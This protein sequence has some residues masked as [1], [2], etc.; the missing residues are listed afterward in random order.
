ME[1]PMKSKIFFLLII[2][3]ILSFSITTNAINDWTIMVYLCG[4]NDLEPFSFYDVDEMEKIGAT[5]GKNGTIE[6]LVLWDRS[7]GYTTTTNDWEGTRL[8]RIVHDTTENSIVSP[9]VDMG[10]KN[11]GDPDTVFDFVDFCSEYYK[12]DKYMLVFWDH[13]DGWY[14]NKRQEELKQSRS[15]CIDETS[16]DSLSTPELNE[17]LGRC[18]SSMGKPFEIVGFDACLMQMFEVEYSLRSYA[19]YMIGSEQTEPG[20]GWPYDKVLDILVKNPDSIDTILEGFVNEYISSYEGNAGWNVTLSAVDLWKLDD[21]AKST[22]DFVNYFYGHFEENYKLFRDA[23]FSVCYYDRNMNVD[24]YHFMS[25][26]AQATTDPSLKNLALDVMEKITAAVK[27]S[28]ITTTNTVGGESLDVTNSFGMAIY[29]PW[30]SEVYD[31]DNYKNLI[32]S[33]YVRWHLVF[34]KFFAYSNG[35]ATGTLSKKIF[36]SEVKILRAR[37]KND[38]TYEYKEVKESDFLSGYSYLV[39]HYPNSPYEKD[40]YQVYMKYDFS[41]FSL[42]SQSVKIEDAEIY[43]WTGTSQLK[44]KKII[45]TLKSEKNSDYILD[46]DLSPMSACEITPT[47]I[48]GTDLKTQVSYWIKNGNNHGMVIGYSMMG[49]DVGFIKRFDP[50]KLYMQIKYKY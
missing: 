35:T 21:L 13:G 33:R 37:Q 50:T 16:N 4:D 41:D 30:K 12:A 32:F 28:K 18:F 6:I 44:D 3:I 29:A 1:V 27:Y 17:A 8:Y 19:R 42:D 40:Y 47:R 43:H 10:E 49:K 26:I 14:R 31:G 25:L 20:N 9:Y 48:C 46:D 39:G 24:F 15:V 34:E 11:M 23:V 2:S 22:R 7:P 36:P 5:M 38:G 45:A